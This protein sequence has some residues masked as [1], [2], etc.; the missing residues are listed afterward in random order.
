MRVDDVRGQDVTW[1]PDPELVDSQTARRPEFNYREELVPDYKLP[2]PL[3]ALDGTVVKNAVAWREKRRPELLELFREHVYGRAPDRPEDMTFRVVEEHPSALD[4]KAIR[5]QVKVNFAGRDDGPSME[6]LVYLPLDI[7]YPVPVFIGLNFGGNHTIVSDPAVR[8]AKSWVRN[9]NS[10]NPGNKASE[11]RRGASSSRWPVEMILERG[12]GIA[13]VYY[14]DI[15][16]DFHDGFKNGVHAMYGERSDDAWGSIAAWAWGLSRCMDYFET[17]DDID[18][19]RVAVMGHSRLGKTALWAGAQDERFALVISNDSGCGGAALSRRAFGET[20]ERINDSFPHW[21]CGNFKQY[22]GNESALPVDQH[23]AIALVA[24]RPVYVASAD[25]DL[26]ADPRGEFLSAKG[27]DPVYRMLGACGLDVDRMPGLEQPVT[28][29]IGHHIRS[30][31]HNVTD[32][33]WQRYMDFADKHLDRYS[34]PPVTELTEQKGLPDPFLKPDGTRVTS[35]SEWNIQR[36]YLK[37]MLAHYQYGHMPPKPTGQIV[38]M[39]SKK[40]VFESSAEERRYTIT[41]RRNGKTMNL[42]MAFI[43]PKGR[44]PFPLIIKNDRDLFEFAAKGQDMSDDERAFREAVN[45]GYIICKFARE[46]LAEDHMDNRDTGV[47]PLYPEYDWGA[48][49]AWAWGYQLV[50]DA[51]VKRSD[52]DN[53][54]IVVTGHSRGGK[55]ALCGGIYDERITICAPNSSGTGGTG[56]FRYFEHGQREQRIS[57]HIGKNEHWWS[58]LFFTL[59]DNESRAPFDAHINKA[60]IAPRGLVNA[61][62]RQDYWAN[63]YGTELTHRAAKEVYSWLDAGDNIGIHWREGSHAQGLEDWRA[64]LDFAD[65]YFFDKESTRQFDELT[66]PDATVPKFWHVPNK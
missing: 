62:A 9:R 41:L 65:R 4:G 38:S 58:S 29:T 23:M 6:I 10:S 64:L 3:T 40:D 34:F 35:E 46:D 31:P 26:W 57:V 36:K 24:P 14:G 37:A 56:S 66:Y 42:R 32:Y 33:D 5:R 45:R 39:D 49:A 27:A 28:G 22:G 52:I 48:I 20:V 11:R 30:G 53:D 54:K 21:F 19:E 60:L 55:A 25:R 63:P 50:I 17:D 47:F 51:V 59:A 18:H 16:P 44:G 1:T 61:H 15:D 7:A 8:L 43:K 12:Y 2:D 13:T